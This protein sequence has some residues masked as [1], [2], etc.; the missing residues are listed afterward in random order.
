MQTQDIR[1][2][3]L[4]YFK[5]KN[6]TIVASA[7]VVPHDDPTLLFN[8]AGMN[9]FKDVFL[10]NSVRDYTRATSSQ[11]SI[12]VGGKHNDLDNVGHTHRHLTFFEMLGNFSFGDYFKKEAIDFSWELS[13]EVFGFDE[14]KIWAT[15]FR[16][17]DEAF[18]LWKKY[19]PE[20]KI[21]RF[22][23]KD[24]FW[25]MGDTGPCGPCSEL[26][27]DR[28]DKYGSATHPYEDSTGDRFLEFWNLVFMQ[29][30]KDESGVLTP[31][32]NPCIDT[33]AGL[34]RVVGLL[35]DVESV[36]QTDVLRN[37][38]AQIEEV[39]GV[40]YDSENK[41]MA[42]AFHVIADHLRALSFA[43]ADGAQPSNVDRGYVLRKI[44]RRAVRYG[45]TL[46]MH[47]PF[48]A[49]VYP[50]LL[51]TMGEDYPE[52]KTAQTRIQDILTIEEEAF[53]RTLRR[54]G[55]ILSEIIDYARRH[56]KRISGD[57]AFKLKDTYGFPIEEILLIAKDS[58][59]HVDLDRYE[60]LEKEA[61][62][63]S[64]KVHK[65]TKQVAVENLFVDHSKEHGP[66]EFAGYEN[67]VCE[68]KVTAIV[69]DGSFVESIVAGKKGMIILDKSSFYAEMGGQVG[70]TGF[71]QSSE[72]LF[73]VEDCQ[74]PYPGVTAHIG[75]VDK[76]QLS[77]GDTIRCEVDANR[78]QKVANNHTATHL[79]HW[80]LH[81]VLGEHVRQAGSVVDDHRLR[82]DFSHH[83]ALSN[84]EIRE[85]EDLVNK[86]IREN[87]PVSSY[88]LSYEEVQKRQDIRQFFG[89]KYGEKVRVVD[90]DYSKELCGGTH[91]SHVGN[92]GFFRITKESS[93]AAGVRRIEATSGFEAESFS[94]EDED[95]LGQLAE[96]LKTH[97]NKLM[98]RVQKLVEENRELTQ[99]VKDLK[100]GQMGDVVSTVMDK[101][102]VI[103]GTPVLT[104]VVSIEAGELRTFSGEVM[105]KMK[106]GV[107]VLGVASNGKC[108]I[109]VKVS[110]N[111]QNQGVKANEIIKAIAPIIGGGGGGKADL[112]QA[113]GKAPEK[114]Q[115]ALAKAREL[116]EVKC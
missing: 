75:V 101:L 85:I 7:P 3:F 106:S 61:R 51:S 87:L 14:E 55:N 26:H 116:F 56:A 105:D 18:E 84:E 48:L 9:Q 22:D 45:R 57:D 102:E 23:E 63:R 44:L 33:G 30:N 112:A 73:D 25:A 110:D 8:N 98:S 11:K 2:K 88:E 83:K 60:E 59:L 53:I 50:R 89:D 64:R 78:R 99:L 70:D 66:C 92:I 72:G 79:L 97:P 1:R 103:E 16:E 68:G 31:L 17:D 58:G 52:L 81:E 6:H 91:T 47:E 74:A 35:M 76:G 114:L 39:S 43:I 24:N 82:F 49:K 111:L 34:E 95:A 86:K 41:V 67:T 32:P 13:T 28:G 37:L 115:E 94:R 77:L 38:I 54:G 12:R 62:E 5:E 21:V 113:G 108:N 93:I 4:N 46:G 104:A 36:F 96:S 100:K 107:L 42:P 29:Y 90:I 65:S 80:A 69:V 15:V 71:L 10:G 27:Y 20:N 109:L 40:K 19:L